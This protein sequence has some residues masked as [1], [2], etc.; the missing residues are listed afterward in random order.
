MWEGDHRA[1][2]QARIGSV[3]CVYINDTPFTRRSASHPHPFHG[4]HLS[5]DFCPVFNF[6]L[7]PLP[8]LITNIYVKTDN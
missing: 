6:N 4:R 7:F 5:Q 3:G 8:Y 1:F 2:S